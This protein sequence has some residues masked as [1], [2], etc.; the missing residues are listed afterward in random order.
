MRLIA[1]FFGACN[2]LVFYE[3]SIRPNVGLLYSVIFSTCKKN[4]QD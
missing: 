2:R 3:P 4:N 1:G